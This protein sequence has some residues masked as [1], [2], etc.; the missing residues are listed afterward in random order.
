MTAEVSAIADQ[1]PEKPAKASG[2][3]QV[4]PDS[5]VPET[6]A[7]LSAAKGIMI[8]GAAAAIFWGA[9]AAVVAVARN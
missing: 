6:R 5:E 1:A 9:V 2:L 7:R 8:A 3:V 4:A